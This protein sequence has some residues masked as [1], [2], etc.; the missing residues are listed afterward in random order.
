MR[1]NHG[2][3]INEVNRQFDP[4]YEPLK[5]GRVRTTR[6]LSFDTPYGPYKIPAGRVSDLF[7]G[8]PDTGYIRFHKAA[9]LH[10]AMR[11]DDGTPRIMSDIC[12]F[13][14]MVSAI[15]EI[16][17]AYKKTDCPRRVVDV[18]IRRLCR[19]SAMYLLGVSGLIG[20]LYLKL[21][22]WF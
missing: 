16:H 14:E 22:K 2:Q 20:S 13:L 18:E 5:K 17:A 9:L 6:D 10:D 11:G 21:D 3:Y 7:T 4:W 1:G 19:L 8:V 15:R 12:F